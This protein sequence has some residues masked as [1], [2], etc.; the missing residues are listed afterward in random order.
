MVS[1]LRK[2]AHS[3]VRVAGRRVTADGIKK[4]QSDM[5]ADAVADSTEPDELVRG[6][7]P[8]SDTRILK[9]GQRQLPPNFVPTGSV[10][11]R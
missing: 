7:Y 3:A 8:N 5:Q 11:W 2:M 1:R 4:L 10:A 6:C 9:S